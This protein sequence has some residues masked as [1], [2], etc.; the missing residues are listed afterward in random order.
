MAHAP[1]A[2]PERAGAHRLPASRGAVHSMS[3]SFCTAKNRAQRDAAPAHRVRRCRR[4]A[5]MT[6]RGNRG[7]D[8]ERWLAVALRTLHL[9]GVVWVGSAVVEGQVMDHAAMALLFASGLALWVL[10]LLAG[11]MALREL[12][13]VVVLLKLALVAWMA[14]DAR[15]AA[16]IFWTLLVVSSFASHAPKDFRHWPTRR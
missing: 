5:A 2:L 16:W 7:S 4:A 12:A 1:V 14:F 8:A 10:D 3:R 9:A 6:S 15:H 13:G 11:R